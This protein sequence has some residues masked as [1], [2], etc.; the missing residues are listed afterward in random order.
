[1]IASHI[2][3]NAILET[4]SYDPVSPE[5]FYGNGF[6]SNF[7]LGI[8]HMRSIHFIIRNNIKWRINF[9]LSRSKLNEMNRINAFSWSIVD[10]LV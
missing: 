9:R 2:T 5:L 8:I 10:K 1:L 4:I 7:P 3:C 6:T